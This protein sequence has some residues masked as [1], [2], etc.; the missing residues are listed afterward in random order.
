MALLTAEK[1]AREF[2]SVPLDQP[3]VAT[4]G[5]GNRSGAKTIALSGGVARSA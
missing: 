4:D 5:A 1:V 3:V 2:E